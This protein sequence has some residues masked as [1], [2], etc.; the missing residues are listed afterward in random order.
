MDK[1]WNESARPRSCLRYG[2]RRLFLTSVVRNLHAQRRRRCAS[3]KRT[4][5]MTRGRTKSRDTAAPTRISWLDGRFRVE[6]AGRGPAIT[7][8][9]YYGRYVMAQEPVASAEV[10]WS[11]A[12]Q[13]CRQLSQGDMDVSSPASGRRA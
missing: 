13:I 6:C 10:A 12:T 2:S 1:I 9:V 8:T 5:L 7:L 11:R 3:I 4:R